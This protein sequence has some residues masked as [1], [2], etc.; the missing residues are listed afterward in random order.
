[1]IDPRTSII[2]K[3]LRPARRILIYSSAKGGV[4]KSVCAVLSALA[5][6]EQG[7]RVG[8]LDLDFQG[9][10]AH[11]LLKAELKFPEEEAGLKPQRVS[12]RL[13][14][15]TFAAFSGERP[16]PLRGSEVTAAI[17]E[18]LAVTIWDELDFLVVDMPPGIGDEVLDVLRFFNRAEFLVICTPSRIVV[19]VVGR[20]L[21]LLR[22]LNVPILGLI[23]NM[24]VQKNDG[25][26]RDLARRYDTPLL[27][28]IPFLSDI[29]QV[30]DGDP[31]D[32]AWGDAVNSLVSSL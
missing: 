9:A 13:D 3:R 29:D 4:G 12:D 17:I 15:M 28:S 25:L 19:P 16:V 14:F 24:A 10:S 26:V 23:E 18:L 8:L 6:A 7:F 20:L 31:L 11:L 1:M 32:G 2:D 30:L 5:L 21:N 27:A 22:S